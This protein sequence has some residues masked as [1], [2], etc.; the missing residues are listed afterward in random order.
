MTS[1]A[2]ATDAPLQVMVERP[3]SEEAALLLAE[4]VERQVP[5]YLPTYLPTCR[6]TSF[7]YYC[8]TTSILLPNFS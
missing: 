4:R 1:H 3:E 7:Y 8:Y 6:R 5:T 2:S